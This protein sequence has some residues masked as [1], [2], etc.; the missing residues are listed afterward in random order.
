LFLNLKKAGKLILAGNV[1]QTACANVISTGGLLKKLPSANVISSGGLLKESA[2][3][4][5][6]AVSLSSLPVEKTL[7][8]AVA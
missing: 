7:A 5:P 4:F 1:K 6:H 8:L 2:C 3:G